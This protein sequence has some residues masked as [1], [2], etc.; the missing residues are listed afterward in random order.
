[1]YLRE[2][3]DAGFSSRNPG[4][5]GSPEARVDYVLANGQIDSYPAAWAYPAATIE[6]A[7]R[8]FQ[9]EGRPAT[10]IDWHNDSGDGELPGAKA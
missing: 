2:P 7:I 10:F 6:Q 8:Y 5:T 4:Y 1:M 3:G 9:S